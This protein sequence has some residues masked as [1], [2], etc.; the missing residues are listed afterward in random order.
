MCWEGWGGESGTGDRAWAW[1]DVGLG[2]CT[3][4]ED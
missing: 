1:G 3:Y 4:E 2:L